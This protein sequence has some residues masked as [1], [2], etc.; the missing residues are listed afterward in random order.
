MDRLSAHQAS[1]NRWSDALQLPGVPLAESTLTIGVLPGEGVGP[2]VIESALSVVHAL[3]ELTG[4]KF[5]IRFGGA[6][7]RDAESEYGVPLSRE[8]VGFCQEVFDLGGAILNGPGGGR[9]VYDLRKEF[10]LFFKISPLQPCRELK[11]VCRLKPDAVQGTNIL[12]VRE[13]I[14]GVYQGTSREGNRPNGERFAEQT[15]AERETILRRF[16]ETAARLAQQRKGKMAVV[17]K[18]AGIPGISALW[19]DC[20]V[21]TADS[22]GIQLTMV[23]IDLMAYQLIQHPQDF[24][25]VA[26]P[27]LCGDVLAD[28]GAVLLGSRAVSFSG[29]YAP[30]RAAVYQTNHGAAYD[31]KGSDRANPAGQIFSLAMM[32]R[33]SF[34]LAREAALIEQAVHAAWAEGWRTA[35]IAEPGRMTVGTKEMT[36]R[37]IEQMASAATQSDPLA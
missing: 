10:D 17:Y 7:G 1:T 8:V 19:R 9:Y 20:A 36:L 13:N 35:D 37:V 16:L 31:L 11:D 34:A 22:H 25:V 5:D 6:I 3:G 32:L 24:D 27:N 23:D 4:L 30:N 28:L 26:A 18:D 21:A 12:L 15:F 33:E 14:S 29:N 2:E